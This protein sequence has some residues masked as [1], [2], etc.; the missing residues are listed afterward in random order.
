[1]KK[2]RFHRIG[3]GINDKFNSN[4]PS[5]KP[6]K[7]RV[8][9]LENRFL[10]AVGLPIP[11]AGVESFT[12]AAAFYATEVVANSASST[13]AIDISS[14]LMEDNANEVFVDEFDSTNANDLIQFSDGSDLDSETSLIDETETEEDLD[15]EATVLTLMQY[16]NRMNIKDYSLDYP[17]DVFFYSSINPEC[18]LSTLDFSDDSMAY[19]LWD[20]LPHT[21]LLYF[22]F[23]QLQIIQSQICPR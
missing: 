9:S 19:S 16:F 23:A 20:V 10:L 15:E 13:T 1:M 17:R 5:P 2:V 3:A 8:E 6:R 11:G 14:A 21:N 7:L 22:S 18:D 12:S 4:F